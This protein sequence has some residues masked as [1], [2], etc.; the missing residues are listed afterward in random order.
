MFE[1]LVYMYSKYIEHHQLMDMSALKIKLHKAKF[2]DQAIEAALSWLA[3]LQAMSVQTLVV[4][5]GYF[6]GTRIRIYTEDELNKISLDS[7]NFLVLLE[8]SKVISMMQRE[9]A[10]ERAMMLGL[11]EVGLD[12][13]CWVVQYVLWSFDHSMHCQR[14]FYDYMPAQSADDA[15][16]LSL[17]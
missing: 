10:I 14:V 7:I 2:T 12:E 5:D 11:R 4:D 3:Q 9:L 16:I 13:M 15:Q 8:R 17:H 6:Q 1:I